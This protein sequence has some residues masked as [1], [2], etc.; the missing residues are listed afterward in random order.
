VN[1]LAQDVHITSALV[2]FGPAAHHSPVPRISYHERKRRSPSSDI[3]NGLTL[4][5]ILI[6]VLVVTVVMILLGLA[7]A[8]PI[9]KQYQQGVLFRLERVLGER[10]PGGSADHPVRRCPA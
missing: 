4:V 7:L 2:V 6:I 3:C 8:P 9:V 5:K 10:P 1:L